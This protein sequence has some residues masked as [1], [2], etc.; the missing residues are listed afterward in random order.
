[1]RALALSVA[2]ATVVAGDQQPSPVNDL[3]FEVVSIKRNRSNALGSNGSSERPD[4]GFT[5][6]NAPIMTLIGRAQF[7]AIVPVDMVGLPEWAQREAYDVSATSPLSRPATPQERAGMLRAMLADRV[8]LVTHVEKRQLPVYDLVLARND[9]RL[10]AGIKP[11]EVDCVARAAADRAAAVA[12]APPSRPAITDFKAPP[13]PCSGLRVDG[14]FEGDVTMETLALLLRPTAGRPVVDKT[15]LKGSYRIKVQ[16]DRAFV[17][18]G[19]DVVPSPNAP[20]SLF[21]ALPAQLG[22]K[23]ESSKGERDVL[24]IDRLE[25]PTEN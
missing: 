21:V 19:P 3:R 15:G 13:A 8:R 18:G 22:L 10:G 4:G 23:L 7:P 20:P 1:M 6:L 14:G 2:F 25:R 9:G 5:L 17:G 16:F 11:S 24:V 12:G